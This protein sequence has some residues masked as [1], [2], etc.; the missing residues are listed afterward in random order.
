MIAMLAV[1]CL[2]FPVMRGYARRV[3]RPPGDPVDKLHRLRRANLVWA[4]LVVAALVLSRLE[5]PFDEQV[6]GEVAPVIA[7]V[8][9]PLVIVGSMLGAYL[10]I[11][12]VYERLRGIEGTTRGAPRR[13][14][15]LML[16]LL[17]PQLVWLAVFVL[18]LRLDAHPVIVIAAVVGFVIFVAACGPYLIRAAMPTR[19]PDP[20]DEARLTRVCAAH[21]VTIRGLRVIDTRHDPAVNA[22]FSGFG[23]GPKYVFVT[24]Q[25]METFNNDELA[26]VLAHEIGHRKKHHI[27]IKLTAHLGTVI[28][29]AGAIAALAYLTDSLVPVALA[30]LAPLAIP[31]LMVGSV[32]LVQGTLGVRLEHRA[33][34][35]AAATAGAEPLA[36]ALDKIAAANMLKRRTGWLWNVLQ[37]H[38][39]LD[40][41][42]Q[43]LTNPTEDPERTH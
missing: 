30:P 38:P 2:A 39:G 41:R 23:P 20:A 19:E 4:L 8:A 33:D 43:R 7:L 29:T 9:L 3:E 17:A 11:R 25:L 14:A 18:L 24:D 13:M 21:G 22:L 28:A 36:R 34:D 40:S 10:G 37:Q 26:A 5:R 31:I 6:L 35:Y 12:P 15:R 42:I 27:A 16:V 32:L 1:L